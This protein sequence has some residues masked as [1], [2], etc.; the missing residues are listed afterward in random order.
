MFFQAVNI[1]RSVSRFRRQ[2][3][4]PLFGALIG[5]FGLGEQ[6][7]TDHAQRARQAIK[8]LDFTIVYFTIYVSKE[9]PFPP[10]FPQ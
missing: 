8:R 10:F 1:N 3:I 4:E 2:I 7:K 5:L 9:L 6:V